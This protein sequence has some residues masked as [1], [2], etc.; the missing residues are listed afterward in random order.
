[1]PAIFTILGVVMIIVAIP[2][3][4]MFAPLVLGVIFAHLGWRHVTASWQESGSGIAA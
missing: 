1:M 2:F 3:G 4:M